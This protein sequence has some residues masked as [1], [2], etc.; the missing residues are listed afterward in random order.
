MD[1]E[2]S[3]RESWRRFWRGDYSQYLP[4]VPLSSEQRNY[5]VHEHLAAMQNQREDIRQ[6]LEEH[7]KDEEEVYSFFQDQINQISKRQA[8]LAVQARF[9]M[10]MSLLSCPPPAQNVRLDGYKK[11]TSGKDF[12][13]AL[14]Q[15]YGTSNV[16]VISE[17][18]STEIQLFD[19][20]V[21]TGTIPQEYWIVDDAEEYALNVACF[22]YDWEYE[23][24]KAIFPNLKQFDLGLVRT[25][26]CLLFVKPLNDFVRSYVISDPKDASHV[27]VD[28][29]MDYYHLLDISK[30]IN[31]QP[32]HKDRKINSKT[33][34][35]FLLDGLFGDNFTPKILAQKETVGL[36]FHVV[37]ELDWSKAKLMPELDGIMETDS[38][39]DHYRHSAITEF[40]H[41]S[42]QMFLKCNDWCSVY[43]G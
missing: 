13:K 33:A 36:D 30:M 10:L 32:G 17:G 22:G 12:C 40:C 20:S 4:S 37:M 6:A 9:N 16:S 38:M 21:I 11:I 8:Q 26:I 34:L 3:E 2:C 23:A 27:L 25:R 41:R 35:E 5:M 43:F 14:A 19:G 29:D 1:Y 15:C 18:V 31:S 28:L 24:H 42:F 7:A 39:L